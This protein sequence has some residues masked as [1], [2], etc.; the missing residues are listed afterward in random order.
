MGRYPSATL[1]P[2]AGEFGIIYVLLDEAAE[3][4]VGVGCSEFEAVEAAA[5]ACVVA[6]TGVGPPKIDCPGVEG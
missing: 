2:F 1:R 4:G 5:A 3:G 6:A